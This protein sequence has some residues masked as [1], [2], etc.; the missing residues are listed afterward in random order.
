MWEKDSHFPS[1]PLLM[2]GLLQFHL[3]LILTKIPLQTFKASYFLFQTMLLFF[4]FLDFIIFH[5]RER[6]REGE[7]EEEKHQCVVASHVAPHWGPGRQPRHVPDW[8]PNQGPFG[9]QPMLNPLNH[10]SQGQTMLL[11]FFLAT[12][13]THATPLL[14][15]HVLLCLCTYCSCHLEC[16]LRHFCLIES[17]HSSRYSLNV[18][19]FI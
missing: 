16:R 18:S 2:K 7:R 10:T 1:K 12:C 6:E 14:L 17:T 13:T 5:F 4:F 3:L 19:L 8:E 15:G 9:L 11:M